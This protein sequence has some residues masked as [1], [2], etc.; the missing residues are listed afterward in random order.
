MLTDQAVKREPRLVVNPSEFKVSAISVSDRFCFTRTL[1]IATALLLFG[2][3]RAFFM[4]VFLELE[5][6]FSKFSVRFSGLPKG[7]PLAFFASR[8]CLVL[9]E[10]NC[11]SYSA[12]LAMM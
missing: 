11:A 5:I 6:A 7:T 1:N 8:D 12:M 10:I 3:S 9:V 2:F 4:L